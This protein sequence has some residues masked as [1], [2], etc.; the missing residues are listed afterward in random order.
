MP[1]QEAACD[2]H[3]LLY[4]KENI[5]K[6]LDDNQSTAAA[7]LDLSKAFDSMYHEIL[8][9][10]LHHLNFDE[11]AIKMIKSFLTGRYQ[12]VKLSTCSSDWI[13]LYHGVPQKTVLGPLLFNIYVNDMQQPVKENCRLIHNADDT[14]ISSSHNNLTTARNK[15]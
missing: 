4:A 5:R 2:I 1:S 12:M 6:D 11:K 3:A 9:E 8:L 7:F 10:K 13:Q 15:L 14:M